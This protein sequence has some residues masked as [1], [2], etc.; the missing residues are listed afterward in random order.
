MERRKSH[1][2]GAVLTAYLTTLAVF[3]FIALSLIWLSLNMLI[4]FGYILPANYIEKEIEKAITLMKEQDFF[5]TSILPDHCKYYYILDSQLIDTN[6]TKKEQ[7]QAQYLIDGIPQFS[8]WFYKLVQ[9]SD[10]SVCIIQYKIEMQYKNK[11]LR[12]FLPNAELSLF[13]FIIL[14]LLLLCILITKRFW[15]LLKKDLLPLQ[16]A[17]NQLIAGDLEHGFEHTTIT[18]Y[19]EILQC[20]EQLRT[21]LKQS[22]Q[23]Q[24]N[25][26]QNRVL[27][28][29]AL[30]HDLKTPLTIIDGHAQLLLEDNLEEE[31][32]QCVNAILRN[33][34][35]AQIYVQ[36]LRKTVLSREEKKEV[37][38]TEFFSKLH[39]FITDIANSYNRT[40][41]FQACTIAALFIA[42]QD[43]YRAIGNIVENAMEHSPDG[44][45]IQVSCYLEENKLYIK[46]IDAGTGF[47]KEALKHGTELFYTENKS[48]TQY[49]HMGMGLNFASEVARRHNGMVQLSNTK[50][51]HGCV[52]I[53]LLVVCL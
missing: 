37:T 16:K 27:E 2:I 51:G 6:M 28:T 20:M 24:W 17:T 29:T 38:G 9:F 18:E 35:Q 42:K 50:E 15:N 40:V 32:I 48:R 7:S 49:G 47:S 41:E 4:R 8:S 45:N 13:V 30:I 52:L 46:I 1:T 3:C 5:D 23:Q 19:E 10:R 39:Q 53:Q 33:A 31:Q 22:L 26:Q 44:S 11:M 14:F 21:A 25:M 34:E 36:R 43:I 12:K